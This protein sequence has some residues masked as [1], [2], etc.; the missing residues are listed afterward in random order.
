M[1]PRAYTEGILTFEQRCQKYRQLM[2]DIDKKRFRLGLPE[3]DHHIRGVAPGEV[4]TIIAYSGTYKTALLQNL[5]NRQAAATDLYQLLFSLEMPAE[6]IH[7]REM[8]MYCDLSGV[9]VE[10]RYRNEDVSELE[11][12]AVRSGA[13]RVLVVEEGRLNLERMKGYVS[14]ADVKHGAVGCVGIDYM[15]LMGATAKTL[16][17]KSSELSFG[18]KDFAKEM[19]LPVVVL[20]QVNR[21]YAAS[22]EAGIETDAAKGGGDIEAGCDFMLGMFTHDDDLIMRIL[23]NRNG[24]KG[25][26]YRVDIDKRT[27]QFIGVSEWEPPKKGKKGEEP[28]PF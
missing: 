22:K 19:N 5:L 6:K 16:F 14:M 9:E 2:K 13:N 27:L 4:L 17:E 10:R 28:C 21:Q 20:S 24:D 23:K 7:E 1:K 18:I 11:A 25:M 12:S 8:Q 26:Y 15:G 3:I